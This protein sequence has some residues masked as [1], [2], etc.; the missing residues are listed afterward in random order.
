MEH[1]GINLKENEQYD[2]NKQQANIHNDIFSHSI[3]S[4]QTNSCSIFLFFKD[5]LIIK[6]IHNINFHT[7]PYLLALRRIT[8]LCLKRYPHLSN[9][10]VFES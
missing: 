8:H 6:F 1:I 10:K 7:H 5:I 9:I 2:S 3:P 4:L